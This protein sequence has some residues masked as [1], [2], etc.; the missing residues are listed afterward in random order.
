M[1]SFVKL[2][3][4]TNRKIY[5]LKNRRAEEWWNLYGFGIEQ[6]GMRKEGRMEVQPRSSL[7]CNVCGKTFS[8]YDERHNHLLWHVENKD[9]PRP[10]LSGFS[11][12]VCKTTFRDY[13]K[14]HL[15]YMVGCQNKV[16]VEKVFPCSLCKEVFQDST[17]RHEHYLHHVKTDAQTL[18]NTTE[19]GEVATTSV[20]GSI[21]LEED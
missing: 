9:Q 16:K 4:L 1:K 17:S 15:H 5:K 12:S 18:G 8:Y 3:L 10:K 14:R 6:G 11:C 21:T 7:G 13:E 19:V 20:V 2:T